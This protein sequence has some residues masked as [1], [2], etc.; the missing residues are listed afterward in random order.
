MRADLGKPILNTGRKLALNLH[1]GSGGRLEEGDLLAGPDL[2]GQTLN[3]L[4]LVPEQFLGYVRVEVDAPCIVANTSGDLTQG[5]QALRP[6]KFSDPLAAP[7]GGWLE[8]YGFL[9]QL[10]IQN[11]SDGPANVNVILAYVEE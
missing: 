2:L 5:Q 7:L 4:T 10:S 11:V 3:V 1:Y 8:V 6:V 9:T